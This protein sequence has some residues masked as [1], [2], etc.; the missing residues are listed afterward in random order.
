MSL[1]AASLHVGELGQISQCNPKKP[2][3]AAAVLD[4]FAHCANRPG[5]GP[6]T[7]HGAGR[8]V[9][10]PSPKIHLDLCDLDPYNSM[11]DKGRYHS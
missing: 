11:N 10:T 1:T 9:G 4:P 7:E 2:A 3:A 5:A 6:F 8:R